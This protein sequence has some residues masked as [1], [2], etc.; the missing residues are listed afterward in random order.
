[1]EKA[2]DAL[3]RIQLRPNPFLSDLAVYLHIW[4][5]VYRT[6]PTHFLI[7]IRLI[8]FCYNEDVSEYFILAMVFVEN[9]FLMVWREHKQHN[10]TERRAV[11]YCTYI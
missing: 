1:M 11:E 10:R 2:A 3:R 4:N 9:L 6:V 7:L 5:T 8:T